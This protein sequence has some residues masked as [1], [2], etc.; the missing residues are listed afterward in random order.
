[1]AGIRFVVLA[2]ILLFTASCVGGGYVHQSRRAR[3]AFEHGKYDKALSWYRKQSPPKRDRLL[4]LLDE[5]VILHSA[6]RYQESIDTFDRAIELSD[7]LSGPQVGSKTASIVTNDNIIPYKGSAFE[8]VL[9][10]VFQI[11]NYVG[12]GHYRD[13]LIE[14]RRLHNRFGNLFRE[15]EKDYLRNAFAS[16]IAA[17]VW[18]FNGQ[19][20]DAYIDY[21]KTYKIAG[22]FP[23]LEEA[24]LRDSKRL[25]FLAEYHRWKKIF[26]RSYQ[27][28]A[29]EHGELIILVEE[30]AVPEK[31]STE[32]RHSLQVLPVPIY[33]GPLRRP[34]EMTI[35]ANG[36][37]LGRSIMLY[38]VHE[39]AVK[40]LGDEM[41]GII[42]RGLARLAAKEGAAVAV[43]KEVD[44]DLG[45][46]MGIFVLATNR[47]DIRSWLTLPRSLHVARF[48]LPAGTYDLELLWENHSRKLSGV[49]VQARDQSVFILRVF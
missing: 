28:L 4:Y 14:V 41:P 25:G 3:H 17:M 34:V 19:V 1:V 6:G 21:K 33:R 11:L 20:N 13:A 31:R 8:R 42:A 15:G 5:A 46:L 43:G 10:Q 18:E 36:R 9:M 39:A 32:E 24:L 16:Y 48:A 38:P 29:P 23:S 26:R 22:G 47:A 7:V 37:D 30:G 27:P 45:I 40:S 2:L 44:K 12:L 35:K 49:E